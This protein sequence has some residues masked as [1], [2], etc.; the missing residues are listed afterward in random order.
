M[1]ETPATAGSPGGGGPLVQADALLA[2]F[3]DPHHVRG[4]CALPRSAIRRGWGIRPEVQQAVADTARRLLGQPST[5]LRTFLA[6]AELLVELGCVISRV[7]PELG[8]A[9][10]HDP[11]VSTPDSALRVVAH[12]MRQRVTPMRHQERRRSDRT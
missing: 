12:T 10:V 5:P 9:A 8:Q 11:I 6:L 3:R 4:D 1:G 7:R 2:L